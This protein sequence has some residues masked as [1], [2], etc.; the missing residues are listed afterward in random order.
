MLDD[1]LD[2]PMSIPLRILEQLAEL[3]VI[4]PFPDH[5]RLGRGQMPIRRS[6]RHVHA[7]EVVVLVTA[8]AL[9]GIYST[10]VGSASDLHRVLMAVISLTRK[11]SG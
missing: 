10:P 1:L 8:A 9:N 2:T 4:Q 3:A 7:G 5:G 11:I 6:R